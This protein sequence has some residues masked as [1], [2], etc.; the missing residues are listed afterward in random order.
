MKKLILILATS[1][2]IFLVIGLPVAAMANSSAL[3]TSANGSRS[4][5]AIG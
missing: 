2:G 5:G 4:S 3:A 1:M